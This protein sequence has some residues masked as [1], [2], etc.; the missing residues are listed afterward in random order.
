MEYFFN[1]F[2]L[3]AGI[4]AALVLFR[5]LPILIVAGVR[6]VTTKK[7]QARKYRSLMQRGNV[8]AAQW[9][10]RMGFATEE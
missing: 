2:A 1:G 9:G 8:E 4:L 7:W 5:I 3:V 6:L 10:K